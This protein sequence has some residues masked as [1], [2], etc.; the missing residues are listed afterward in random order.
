MII[1]FIHKWGN[2][3]LERLGDLPKVTQLGSGSL[4]LELPSLAFCVQSPLFHQV[5][6][7]QILN[8]NCFYLMVIGVLKLGLVKPTPGTV[9]WAPVLYQGGDLQE[10]PLRKVGKQDWEEGKAQKEVISGK[11]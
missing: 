9:I 11:V 8:T 6:E 2:Q 4:V 1:V 3:G 5:P 7:F 10:K